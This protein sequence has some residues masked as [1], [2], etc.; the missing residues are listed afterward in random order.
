MA[1]NSVVYPTDN[2]IENNTE[3]VFTLKEE[4]DLNALRIVRDN[5]NV[6]YDKLGS[7]SEFNVE[8]QEW[9]EVD[10]KK[11]NTIIGE[12][13]R[14][15]SESTTVKYS[16]GKKLKN[17]RRF[18]SHSLQSLCRPLR[19]TISKDIYYDVDMRNAHPTFLLNL[20]EK[21][22]FSHPV[23]EKYIKNRDELLDTW[24]GTTNIY[25]K[26][27]GGVENTVLQTKDDVK[28]YF[29]AVLN[30]GG[31][32]KT[33]CTELN[34]FHNTHSQFL[35]M[36]YK[37]PT[38]KNYK[39]RAD[40]K[41]KDK[42]DTDKDNKKGSA[43]NYYMCDVENKALRSIEQYLIANN[44]QYGTLCFDG[45][46]IYKRDVPDLAT[47]ITQLETVL[48]E[49]MLFPI[50]LAEKKMDEY[51]DLTGLSI[52]PDV[53]LTEQDY[54]TYLL[55]SLLPI[56]KYNKYMDDLY[57]YD[58]KDA[59]WKL[60]KVSHLRLYLTDT[61]DKYIE[62]HPDEKERLKALDYIRS[63]SAQNNIIN[64]MLPYLHA[65]DDTKFISENFD[66]ILGLLPIANKQVVDLKTNTVRERKETDYFTKTTQNNIVPI[67]EEDRA[68]AM[69]YYF[70]WLNTNDLSYVECFIKTIGV[71]F[72]GET[73]MKA[74]FNYIGPK[75]S[76]KSSFLT[77]IK[78]MLGEFACTAN[79]R[80]CINQ[81]NKAVHDSETFGLMGKRLA[82]LSE[83][84]KTQSYNT[85]LMKA[86]SGGDVLDI[87]AAG[88]KKAVN[89]LIRCFFAIATNEPCKHDDVAFAERLWCFNFSN[90]FE[91]NNTFMPLL[92]SRNDLMFSLIAEYATAYYKEG[93]V[94]HKIV[95]DF[96]N[97]LND[98]QCSVIT[99]CKRQSYVK[100]DNIK[101]YVE[102]G[103][104]FDKYK[105]DCI[106]NDEQGKVYGKID[107]YK[108]F[109][110]YYKLECVGQIKNKDVGKISGWRCLIDN[111]QE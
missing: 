49:E 42:K 53:R 22:T 51:I 1:T 4:V 95:V 84:K 35:D 43:L 104:V 108:R 54:A 71:I 21:M 37:H 90:K 10:Y 17:G 105:N 8:K 9:V 82:S 36:F 60:Q 100:T 24:I 94:K 89:V 41:Y 48:V 64:M 11:A 14:L 101:N 74:I 33:T 3:D 102:S 28:K 66:C 19:H 67:N 68:I 18:A 16:Y 107:F 55:D 91:P 79:D 30:G 83:T 47:L 38:Y 72:A 110:T 58:S 76:G 7:F 6:V 97:E 88:D 80:V 2:E 65:S 25:K 87:R 5:F 46:M 75:D 59:L 32:N 63:N 15:K 73:Y 96:T 92:K 93:I 109:E 111:S 85:T 52:V 23:L 34:E 106:E 31:N 40:N 57:V 50:R 26:V 103:P 78:D 29:L 99:W 44:I 20:T 77:M 39:Y 81:K 70:E 45:L 69:K 98:K 12:L 27:P 61:L 86:I 13:Y 62:K 56:I